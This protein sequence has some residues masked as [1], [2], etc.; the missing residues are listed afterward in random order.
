MSIS[1]S[2]S[3]REP[4]RATVRGLRPAGISL[5]ISIREPKRLSELSPRLIVSVY[6]Y[7][8]ENQNLD[9][10]QTKGITY[11][12]INIHQRT[13]TQEQHKSKRKLYQFINIHQRTKTKTIIRN[14]QEMYQFINIHQRT[15]TVVY[16][17]G[18]T[19]QYQFINIHQR[20][21]TWIADG[22]LIIEYQFINIH[23]RT[24]TYSIITKCNYSISLSISIREPKQK[25]FGAIMQDVSVYQYPSE[26]QN[27]K[28]L[29]ILRF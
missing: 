2:I 19:R 3:I 23:Q 24:K 7:P 13:K 17:G 10:E 27:R 29:W 26:N 16:Q 12:F 28:M 22:K 11:Q 25:I 4:K 21:K 15:K 9:R 18:T 5:S 8:S 6:Q 20:T 1:L 14:I